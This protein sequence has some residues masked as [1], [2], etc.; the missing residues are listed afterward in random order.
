[1]VIDPDIGVMDVMRADP[2]SGGS[3]AGQAVFSTASYGEEIYRVAESVD[4]KSQCPGSASVT[5]RRGAPV[6]TVL[7]PVGDQYDNRVV[8]GLG[9]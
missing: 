1:V 4:G 7:S 9:H 3:L 6:V 5:V 2:L 8:P